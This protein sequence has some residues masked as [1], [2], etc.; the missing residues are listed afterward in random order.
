MHV[1]NIP[2]LILCGGQ[3]TRIKHLLNGLPKPMYPVLGKPFLSHQIAYLS[4]FGLTNIII[5]AGYRADVINEYFGKKYLIIEEK[6]P[7]GTGGAILYALNHIKTENFICLNG[8]TLFLL[9]FNKFLNASK[10]NNSFSTIA[11]KKVLES[12]RYGSVWKNDK[13]KIEKFAEKNIGTS[14]GLINAGIYY[15]NKKQLQK[16]DFPKK[17]SI[18]TDIFPELVKDDLFG[19][20]TEADF[21]DIGTPE[22]IVQ[23]ENFIVNNNF[24]NL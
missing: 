16:F 12:D 14:S 17:C 8:D 7:L 13:N 3:G 24:T 23:I 5:S 2:V 4:K 9:D 15:L 22:T 19:F 6:E 20:E 21:I 1:N 18:E 11:L 10:V